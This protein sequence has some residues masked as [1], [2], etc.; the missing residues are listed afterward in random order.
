[1]L[2][3]VGFNAEDYG[4]GIASLLAV[5]GGGSRLMPLV[6]ENCVL[7]EVHALLNELPTAQL[8]PQSRSQQAAM[9]GLYL[10]FSCWDEAHSRADSIENQ[11]GYFWHAIVHRQEPD[12]ENSG[13]WFRKTGTHP[14]FA[15]LRAAAA[16]SGYPVG[17]TWDPFAF[18][19]FCESARQR[20]GSKEEQLAVQIQLAE[21]QLLFDYCA[22]SQ[23]C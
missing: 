15:P 8:F 3:I 5:S 7:V 20:P 17:R 12:P 22:R 23:S 11:D 19:E 2:D 14:V 4:S 16:E 6:H 10:Y 13:Y 21:W 9:A 18:I 1:M